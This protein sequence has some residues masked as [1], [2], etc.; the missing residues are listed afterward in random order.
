M[1]LLIIMALEDVILA[2]LDKSNCTEY[3][4]TKK[5]SLVNFF[6]MATYQQIYRELPKIQKR[7]G[8]SV[9]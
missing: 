2:I 6:R 5:L 1:L 3:N 9:K 8:F 7:L 4:L